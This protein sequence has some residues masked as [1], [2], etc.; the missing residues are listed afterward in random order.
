MKEFNTQ[1]S[2]KLY[3]EIT[4]YLVDGV[5]SSFHKADMEEYP[6]AMTHGKG[7]KLYD[8][9]GNEYI[10]YVGGFGPMILGY[11]PKP[12]N[13]AVKAQLELGSQFSAPTEQLLTL[14]RTFTEII[15][16][17][18]TVSFQSTGTEANM[19]AWRVA[20][21]YTGK[22]KIV[23]FAGQYHGWSDE[24]KITV[25]AK[26]CSLEDKKRPARIF[27][28][29]GQRQATTD[30][31]IIAVWN[32]ADLLEKLFEQRNDIA[33]V[34]MEPYMCD[35]G[36]IMPSPGYLESV[37]ELCTKYNIVLIF[38]EV[39]TGARTGFGRRSAVF[40]RYSRSGCIRQSH[41]RRLSSVH[42]LRKKGDH[43]LR[44]PSVRH[45]QCKSCLGS[46]IPGDHCRTEKAR[47][48]RRNGTSWR[49]LLP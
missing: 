39:I 34:V 24:Q 28:T 41:W 19:H 33:A 7:C 4:R 42:D 9:D 6:I 36:P 23:K 5:S 18:E 40:R 32:H 11:C 3:E 14:S 1:N 43:E 13:E 8:V 10:D 17:A 2:K 16:C 37:R 27:D 31:I 22:N 48:I 25:T 49:N 47:H 12:V 15:P 46:R 26:A 38:D 45:F 29:L 44:R 20:R 30:D 35:E 21:A